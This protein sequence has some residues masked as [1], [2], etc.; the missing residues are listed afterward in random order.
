M[1]ARRGIFLAACGCEWVE[2]ATERC[3]SR[4]CALHAATPDL[5][6]AC[7]VALLHLQIAYHDDGPT[8]T[9]LRAAIAK[10]QESQR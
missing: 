7:Q 10:A 6:A 3:E 2:T 4:L 1:S 9:K 8:V 5:L